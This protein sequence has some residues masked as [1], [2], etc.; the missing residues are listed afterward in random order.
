MKSKKIWGIVIVLAFIFLAKGLS[1]VQIGR[2]NNQFYPAIYDD[3]IVWEDDRNGNLDIHGCRY[4][5]FSCDPSMVEFQI[6]KDPYDQCSPAIYGDII[7]WEDKRNGNWDIYWKDINAN[8]E[9][10]ITT[11]PSDQRS[12]AIYEDII[13]WEDKRNGNWDIYGYNY[14]EKQ[15]FRVTTNRNDQCSPAIYEDIIVWEDKRNGNWD[16][17]GYNYSE[18]QEFQITTNPYDQWQPAIYKEIVVWADWRDGDWDIYC[19]TITPDDKSGKEGS[20]AVDPDEMSKEKEF[21]LTTSQEEQWFPAIYGDYVIWEDNRDDNWYI[22]GYNLSTGEEA[23]LVKT[24]NSQQWHP[25]IHGETVVWMDWRDNHWNIC[26]K[27]LQEEK[28]NGCIL[29]NVT[30]SLITPDFIFFNLAYVG[31]PLAIIAIILAILRIARKYS[32]P[33]YEHEFRSPPG[34]KNKDQQVYRINALKDLLSNLLFSGGKAFF[35]LLFLFFISI[36]IINCYYDTLTNID[37]GSFPRYKGVLFLEEAIPRSAIGDPEFIFVLMIPTIVFFL[38]RRFFYYIPEVFT[39]LFA[40]EIIRKKKG[41][42]RESVLTDFNESLKAFEKKINEKCMYFMGFFFSSIGVCIY[43]KDLWNIQESFFRVQFKN[44]ESVNWSN[45][46]FYPVNSMSKAVVTFTIFFALGIIVWKML[47]V[48]HFTRKLN[49]DYELVLKPYDVDG[50]GGFQPLEELWLRM[51][52]MAIPVLIV[53]VSLFILNHFFSTP[54]EPLSTSILCSVLITGLLAYPILSYHSIVEASKTTYLEDIEM[55][56]EE[57]YREMEAALFEEGK[58]LEDH[59]MKQM[60]RLQKIVFD[61]RGIPSLPFKKYQKTY[62]ILSALIPP[63]TGIIS[64]FT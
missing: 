63:I 7:V 53:P 36:V 37:I 29:P 9:F 34:E 4:D 22:W 10:Q 58:E 26:R 24:S 25:A 33:S 57:S 27:E 18:K 3:I 46:Y 8:D 2:L 60:E 44:L 12:P 38:A 64:Y 11:D 13:V 62:I 59:C 47:C 32:K 54:F 43:M 61:V 6:T 5:S 56:I 50:L 49:H 14:S 42:T 55:R 41:S 17:Y 19:I 20:T 1:G 35:I 51:S 30:E 48:V 52:Y 15:E 23:P 28:E 45:F 39:R 16:I 31:V 21:P 40:D